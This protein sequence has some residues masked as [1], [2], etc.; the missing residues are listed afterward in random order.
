MDNTEQFQELPVPELTALR[1]C[2]AELELAPAVRHQLEHA[3]SQSEAQV[4]QR[5]EQT[6]RQAQRFRFLG[7]I[8]ARMV[9]EIRNPLNAIFLHADVVEEETQQPTVDSRA[10]I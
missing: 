5:L 1:Q 9:H 6:V 3:L 8:A 10:Q 2:L 4:R 7:D